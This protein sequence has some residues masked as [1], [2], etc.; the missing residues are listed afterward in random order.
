MNGRRIVFAFFLLCFYVC[1]P[2]LSM[3]WTHRVGFGIRLVQIPATHITL[4]SFSSMTTSNVKRRPIIKRR[5]L[6]MNYP[7][8]NQNRTRIYQTYGTHCFINNY[9][10]QCVNDRIKARSV[11]STKIIKSVYIYP[12][13]SIIYIMYCVFRYR[14][15]KEREREASKGCQRETTKI[16]HVQANLICTMM[17]LLDYTQKF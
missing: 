9:Y 1:C 11:L 6:A 7:V 16:I 17:T 2:L 4:W 12:I 10:N 8:Q 15:H 13:I 3:C 5:H 14:M